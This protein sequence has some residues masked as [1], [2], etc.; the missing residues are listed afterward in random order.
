VTK[1]PEEC[2]ERK[3][4]KENLATT[5]RKVTLGLKE[6]VDQLDLRVRLVLK[7]QKDQRDLKAPVVKQALQEFPVRRAN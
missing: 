1:V 3:E 2:K 6:N 5:G 4:I 7:D